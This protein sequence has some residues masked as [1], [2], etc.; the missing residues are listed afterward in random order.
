MSS[1][2]D[3]EIRDWLEERKDKTDLISRAELEIYNTYGD[4]V[5]VNLKQKSLI[6]YGR[7][8][9]VGTSQTT[10]QQFTGSEIH[11]TYATTNSIT[12]IV[13]DDPSFTGDVLVEGHTISGSDLTFKTQ[14]VTANGFTEVFLPTSLA[15]ATRVKIT[16]NDTL[17][18]NKNIY[19]F[20]G[21]S[22]SGVPDTDNTVHVLLN[23]NDNSSMKASTSISSQ[24]Y[25]ILTKVY[26]G[27]LK[28]TTATVNIKLQIKP[29]SFGQNTFQTVFELP[30]VSGGSP[31]FD[32]NSPPAFVVPKNHDVRLV[33][34]AST[35][36][37]E[38]IGGMAGYLA[39]VIS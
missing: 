29:A 30:V 22:T 8:E 17:A 3:I 28:K 18:S 13:S 12:K 21:S 34:T 4:A 37:V 27:V 10:L 39:K 36:G 35:T 5:S 16:S 9:S 7:N 19:V 23:Q 26:G 6:K 32:M 24:D 11:E 14:T 20:S 38:V 1:L 25:W 31:W 33:A 2:T 15:R